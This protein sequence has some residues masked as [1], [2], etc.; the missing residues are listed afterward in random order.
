MRFSADD[1]AES[2]EEESVAEGQVELAEQRSCEGEPGRA[3]RQARVQDRKGGKADGLELERERAAV[4]VVVSRDQAAALD[5]PDLERE[6]IRRRRLEGEAQVVVAEHAVGIGDDRGAQADAFRKGEQRSDLEFAGDRD[7]DRYGFGKAEDQPEL[8][9]LH[10]AQRKVQRHDDREIRSA[11]EVHAPAVAPAEHDVA[12]LDLDRRGDDGG[13]QPVVARV[14]HGLERVD[15]AGD[16]EIVAGIR[17]FTAQAHDDGL[18]FQARAARLAQEHDAV[19]WRVR[20]L[21]GEA[22]GKRGRVDACFHVSPTGPEREH[23]TAHRS[24]R[25]GGP[26]RQAAAEIGGGRG[27]AVEVRRDGETLVGRAR[28]LGLARYRENPEAGFTG[29]RGVDHTAC[30]DDLLADEGGQRFERRSARFRP[31]GQ[32]H[33]HFGVPHLV[34]RRDAAEGLEDPRQ[35]SDERVAVE[36]DAPAVGFERPFAGSLEQLARC[37]ASRTDDERRPARAKAGALPPEFPRSGRR[38]AASARARRRARARSSSRR[39]EDRGPR[40]GSRQRR[41]RTAASSDPTEPPHASDEMLEPIDCTAL[42]SGPAA[43]TSV[44][45]SPASTPSASAPAR[46][47]RDS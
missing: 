10:R 5:R 8:A 14:D 15:A 35:A 41:H 43:L 17:D 31:I 3:V 29:S 27:N 46:R 12:G 4:L 2:G 39:G 42:N 26:R 16:E 1:A 30:A 33:L 45:T 18:G 25:A 21:D 7:G 32:E 24:K 22:P 28:G 34:H 20:R 38:R 9:D 47:P 23:D 19:R 44:C 36:V 37:D 11:F 40:T 6:R 13:E